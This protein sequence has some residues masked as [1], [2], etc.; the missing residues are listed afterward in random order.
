MF[1]PVSPALTTQL[2]FEIFL[3]VRCES[4]EF[5]RIVPQT[6]ATLRYDSFNKLRL[7]NNVTTLSSTLKQNQGTMDHLLYEMVG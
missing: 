2:P 3:D 4:S 7:R 5:Q 6:H 1:Q